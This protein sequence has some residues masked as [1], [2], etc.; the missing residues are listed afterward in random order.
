MDFALTE[1]QV[2][3][4]DMAYAFGQA[5]IA[6]HARDWEAAGTI[7]KDLWPAGPSRRLRWLHPQRT[8]CPPRPLPR[9]LPCHEASQ[10]MWKNKLA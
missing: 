10:W 3:I 2:A 9:H 4:F 7:P 1:E 8:D 6:P 5:E